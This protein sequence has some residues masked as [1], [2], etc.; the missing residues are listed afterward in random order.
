MSDLDKIVSE[1][2]SLANKEKA[3]ILSSFF[4][5]GKGEYG[6]GDQFLGITVPIQRKIATNYAAGASK[7]TIIT[8]LNSPIH[9]CRHTAIFMLC[10]KFNASRKI[11]EEKQWVTL[12]LRKANR[13]NNWDLVD[14]S[15]HVILGKWLEDKDRGILYKFANSKSLWKNRIA[16][17]T[18]LH[19]IKKDDIVDILQLSKM[20]LTHPH[21][22]IHKASGWMLREAWK[23]KPAEIERFISSHA[24][25][26]PRT[27]LR[28]AIEKMSAKKRATF[29]RIKQEK[30]TLTK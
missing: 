5:S 28:Y 18:T 13:I 30:R 17:I 19:F 2:K 25:K 9:E 16:L 24:S 14:S 29:M 22:L 10:Y 27:M 1:L 3:S 20:M 23:R 11:H 12:Y 7:E 26:M 21:D 6:E 4:K 8:L 15:A